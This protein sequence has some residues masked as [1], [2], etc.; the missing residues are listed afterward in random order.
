VR[1]DGKQYKFANEET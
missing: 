1:V